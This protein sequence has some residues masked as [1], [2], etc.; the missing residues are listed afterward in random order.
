[1][2]TLT[3]TTV[4]RS[5]ILVRIPERL[6]LSLSGII[7]L[8]AAIWLFCH[9]Y[10]TTRTMRATRPVALIARIAAVVVVATAVSLVGCGAVTTGPGPTVTNSGTPAGTYTVSVTASSGSLT[11]QV[12]LSLIVK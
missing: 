7:S 8:M 9:F 12:N 5:G 6:P 3:V 1:M 4:G 10:G 2:T 11:H